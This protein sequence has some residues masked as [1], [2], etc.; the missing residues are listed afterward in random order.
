LL[1]NGNVLVL[2]GLNANGDVIGTAELFETATSTFKLAAIPGLK[3]R[4]FH[5]ATLLTD[6]TILIAGGVLGDGLV[7]ESAEIWNP[8]TQ[9]EMPIAGELSA[10]RHSHSATLLADGAVLLWGG[11]DSN[12]Q[13]LTNGDLYDPETQAFTPIERVPTEA[14]PAAEGPSL[15]ASIPEDGAQNVPFRGL[16]SVRFSERLSVTTVNAATVTL[17][18]PTGNLPVTVVPAE[19]GILAFI[20]PQGPL[21][22]DATYTLNLSG[23]ADSRGRALPS[24]QITFSTAGPALPGDDE[25]WVPSGLDWRTHRPDSPWQKMPPLKAPD[26]T[27]AIA[28]QVL[29]L[30]GRPLPNVTLQ[31]DKYTTRSDSTGRFLLILGN[32]MSR[33]RVLVMNGAT[34]NKPGK[35]YGLFQYGTNVKAAIT[36]VLPFTIWMPLLDTAHA[37]TVPSPTKMDM[38]IT[39]PLLPGLKLLLPAGTVIWDYTWHVARTISITPIPLDRTPFPLPN[40]QVPIYFTIQPGGAWLKMTNPKGPPGAQLYYPNTYHNPPGTP[41]EFWNYEPDDE[42]WYVYGLGKVSPD[43]QTIVPNPGVYIYEFTGAMVGGAG[44]PTNGPSPCDSSTGVPCPHPCCGDPIDLSTG[45]FVHT[46]TDLTLTDV[47][48][49]ALTRTYRQ[50]DPISRAFGVGTSHPYDIFLWTPNRDVDL[51]LILQDGGRIHFTMQSGTL[52]ECLDSPTSFHGATLTSSLGT[53]TWIVQKKDGT[54]LTFPESDG[55]G[56]PLLEALVGY[57]DRYGNALTFARDGRGNLTRIT[58]PN[59]RYIDFTLD[60]LGRI[61][62]ARDNIGRTVTYSYDSCGAGLL[63]KVTDANGGT[64]SYTYDSNGN[65]TAI[66]NPRGITSANNTYDS[67]NRAISQSRSDGSVYRISYIIENGTV[68]QATETDPRNNTRKVIFNSSGYAVADTLAVG[69]AQQELTTYNWDSTTGLLNSMVDPLNRTTSY[70]YDGLGNLLSTTQ[71]SGTPYAITTS[72][73]YNPVFNQVSSFKDP[74]G[75]I[76]TLTYG[77]SGNLTSLT[78]PLNHQWT[79]TYNSQG[80]RL[81]AADPL[82]NTT[83]FGYLDGDLVS[84]TDPLDRTTTLGRDGAGRLASLT[85]AMGATTQYQYDG[86]S[87]LTQTTDPALTSTSFGYDQDHNLTRVTDALNRT[88]NYTYDKLDRLSARQDPLGN[89]ESYTYDLTGN[90]LTFTDRKGQKTTF[91]YDPLNRRTKALYSDASSTSYTYD[92][93]NRLTQISDTISGTISR[94]YDALDRLRS[95]S[96]PE[97]TVSYAYDGAN[98]RTMMTVAGQ[99][100]VSYSYDNANRL[101]RI[102]QGTSTF[103]MAYDN[104]NRRTALT[105]ANGVTTNYSYDH[106]SQ[107]AGLTYKSGN[108]T[109]GSLIYSYDA[110]GRRTSIGGSYARTDLPAAVAS[111]SYNANNQLTQWGSS[112]ISYDLDGNLSNDGVNTYTWNA[113]NQLASINSGATARFQYDGLGRRQVK[114]IFGGNT[115]F[116]YDGINPVQELSGTA[117][118]ANLVTGLAVDEIFSRT[119]SVG[120]RYFL[121]DALESTLALLDSTGAVRTQYTYEPFGRTTLSGAS[122][123][124]TYQYTGR[125]N[126]DTGLY[127]YRARYYNPTAGR[128][129]SE[130]PRAPYTRDMDVYR[131]AADNPLLYRDPLG[132]TATGCDYICS[133]ET[134]IVGGIVGGGLPGITVGALASTYICDL[135]CHPEPPPPSGLLSCTIGPPPPPPPPGPGQCNQLHSCPN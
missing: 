1:P 45:L 104:A 119:D 82:L 14:E 128:F 94:A 56:S 109:L 10:P 118:T 50:N 126:D 81:T 53:G 135:I 74:L 73:T 101:T 130:D 103:S 55:S 69:T 87:D 3:P 80:Q 110:A 6:G 97:G 113:R 31:V 107:L 19:T 111:A 51:Y 134:A 100:A 66:T 12:G 70:T 24:T 124:D 44:A 23:L 60:P 90:L 18:G 68:A 28:G 131:Y 96:T 65:M 122:S 76:T 102:T 9:S 86:L 121:S 64:T 120:A 17:S 39:N 57:K 36:N 115:S 34:A 125:E 49:L 88:T 25:I 127:Y 30:N 52:W 91:S 108:A 78:D 32:G 35:T 67:N 29:K 7:T 85:D 112:T 20:T 105:L 11:A 83:K 72:Y 48:P 42:G 132:L 47:I 98:R 27:T 123:G 63:C 61:I 26:G 15:A 59:G 106:A 37:V 4:A 41:Y 75:H 95:E 93:G 13:A 79:F 129:I 2:G 8:Q 77:A 5:T 62:Q 117:V 84:V 43:G 133:V 21:L 46:E 54:V 40:V 38:I 89:S 114:S 22:P 99:T 33:H 116:L 71:L 92:L 58:S 16:I